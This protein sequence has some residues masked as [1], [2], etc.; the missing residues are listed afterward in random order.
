MGGLQNT[1][2]SMKGPGPLHQS[3]AGDGVYVAE[4][5]LWR[6]LYQFK[7]VKMACSTMVLQAIFSVNGMKWS[8]KL[9]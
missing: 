8:E 9:L 7:T 2:G 5:H 3:S 6:F 4:E 1:R